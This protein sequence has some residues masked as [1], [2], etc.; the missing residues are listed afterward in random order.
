MYGLWRHNKL[1]TKSAEYSVSLARKQNTGLG[2][3]HKTEGCEDSLLK[4]YKKIV[5]RSLSSTFLW[6]FLE[7]V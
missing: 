4:G 3:Y 1:K 6:Q 2:G 5:F 7:N